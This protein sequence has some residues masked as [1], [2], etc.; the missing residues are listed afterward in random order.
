MLSISVAE[1]SSATWNTFKLLAKTFTFHLCYLSAQIRACAI[2][3]NPHVDFCELLAK[4]L[5]LPGALAICY[6]RM[7]LEQ[8][9]GLRKAFSH[10]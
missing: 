9:T 3:E 4:I 5:D 10:V 6:R 1:G 8:Q 7:I 2:S